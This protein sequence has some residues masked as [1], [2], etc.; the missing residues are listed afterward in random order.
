MVGVNFIPE[1]VQL[2]Q[3]RRRHLWR[4]GAAV[5]AAYV[6]LAVPLGVDF[7]QR[8]LAGNL[9]AEHDVLSGQLATVRV[10]LRDLTARYVP[11][12]QHCLWQ[13]RLLLPQEEHGWVVQEHS[14]L[15]PIH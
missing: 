2:A 15:V 14:H 5:V 3:G 13:D 1:T 10:E 7:Y 9:R 4:W 11:T 12:M 6:A 8:A